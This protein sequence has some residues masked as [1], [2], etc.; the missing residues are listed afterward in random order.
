MKCSGFHAVTGAYVRIEGDALLTAVE[1]QIVRP[2]SGPRLAPA[3]I[4]LQINGFAGADYNNPREPL[5]SIAAS[6]EKLFS[7]GTARIFPTVITGAPDDMAGAL[8]NLAHARRQLPRGR[9]LEAFHV[10][11]PF[12]SP[13]DGPRGAHPR[14][15]CR[16]PDFDE[17]RRWQ[18][19]AEGLV[20][21]VTLSPEWPGSNEF[22]EKLTGAGVV[23]A[24]GHTKATDEEIRDAVKAGA[25]LSTH[26]GNGSHL[27]LRRHPNYIW[28]QLAEDRLNATFIV[29]G[30]HLGP[31]FLKTALRAKGLERSI[32]I[33][34]AV[35]PAMMPPGDYMIGEVEVELKADQRVVLRGGD[36][37]AGSSLRMDRG[38]QQLI[39]LAGLSL[40]EAVT[41]ATRNAAR[42]GRVSGRLR[43][44]E[45]GDRADVTVFDY[46]AATKSIRVLETWLDGE[47]V[48]QAQS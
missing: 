16:P 42:A 30:I 35:A 15:W 39:R 31:A 11:G 26:L 48:Y 13:E 19:A 25:T 8:A 14:R 6:L 20:R 32:L 7:T 36:R 17:Y 3:F 22:I 33:T 45:P 10:E 37:L 27:E 21:L 28:E 38:V 23:A 47:R 40:G 29:D 4:D 5:D 24:I 46:D 34:D 18:D 9:A 41:M 43:G 12:I 2:E 1:E 44:L